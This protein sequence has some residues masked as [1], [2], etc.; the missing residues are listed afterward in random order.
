MIPVVVGSSP[1]SHPKT[2]NFQCHEKMALD[3]FLPELELGLLT[4][5]Q[6]FQVG[7]TS[8]AKPEVSSCTR[9]RFMKN[10]CYVIG[11][12]SQIGSW[13]VPELVESDWTVHLISRGI[14]AKKDYGAN[15]FWH[16][17]DLF[18][19]EKEL[20]PD[21]ANVLFYTY[22]IQLLPSLLESFRDRGIT[23]VIAF[24]STSRFT[25]ISSD[26]SGD[27]D[28]AKTLETA[29]LAVIESC[30]RLGMQWTIFR[31]TMIYAGKNGDRNVL[32]IANVISRFGFFPMFG[33]AKGLRQPV[34]AADLATA[35][36]LSCDNDATFNKSYNLGGAEVLTYKA[37]V[38]RIFSAMSRKPRFIR[39]PIWLFGLAVFFARKFPRFSH[40]TTSM[41]Q[42]M[43]YDM[44]FSFD[45]AASDFGYAPRKFIPQLSNSQAPV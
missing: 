12:S 14:R 10:S 8:Y 34:H 42:R 13:L 45:D 9:P 17:V 26:D 4:L 25:K 6:W 40:I 20:P 32:D 7:F 43:Q 44:T 11:A 23:R 2:P 30:E 39:T 31:P 35:C 21:Q 27:L 16:K 18:D 15:A 33:N 41:A 28:T 37:M 3:F 38:E 1:I 36:M 19:P 5:I 24:S 29:E 22:V